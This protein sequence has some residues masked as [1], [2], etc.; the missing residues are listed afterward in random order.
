MPSINSVNC[1]LCPNTT[2]DT[3]VL[4]DVSTFVSEERKVCNFA[5]QIQACDDDATNSRAESVMIKLSG[6]IL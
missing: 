1:G 2:T 4:C 3:Q 5:V 6:K